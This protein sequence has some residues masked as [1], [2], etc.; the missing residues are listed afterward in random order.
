MVTVVLEVREG[1]RRTSELRYESPTLLTLGR[2]TDRTLVLE[3]PA[4][5][6]QLSRKHCAVQIT[7]PRV[8]VR[9]LGSK[10]GTFVNGRRLVPAPGPFRA[11]AKGVASRWAAATASSWATSRSRCA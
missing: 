4:V 9:D 3:D 10:N 11:P 2:G 1:E 6:P 5:P 8:W 7:P